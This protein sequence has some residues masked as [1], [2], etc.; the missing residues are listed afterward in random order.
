MGDFVPEELD[1]MLLALMGSIKAKK[2][3]RRFRR[4]AARVKG[5]GEV[6]IRRERNVCG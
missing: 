5:R 1:D 6:M 3:R 4:R 2:R